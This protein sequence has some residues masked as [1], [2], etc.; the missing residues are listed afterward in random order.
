MRIL[1]LTPQLPYPL[2]QGTAI[3]NFGLIQGLARRHE[4]S[5]LSFA[6]HDPTAGSATSPSPDLG[7]LTQLCHRVETVAVPPPRSI[8][9]R[10]L[11]TL[12]HPLPDMALRLASPAFA[13][14]LNTWLQQETFDI[15]HVEGIEMTPY[16]QQLTDERWAEERNR[17]TIVFDDHNCE[18][19]LQKRYAQVDA[20][21][22]RRWPGALYSLVQW[23]KLRRYEAAICRRAHHVLAVSQTDALALQALVPGLRVT[24]IPNGIDTDSYVLTDADEGQPGEPGQPPT[25]VFI[26]KMDFRPNVDAV[27]WFASTIWP[28][29]RAKVPEARFLAVGQ[30]PHPQL[31]PLRADPSVTLTGWV[32]QVEPYIKAATLYV[33]PLRMGSGTRLK[34][35]EAMVLGKAIV[36]TRIGAEGLTDSGLIANDRELRLVEDDDPDG[37]SDAVISLLH[38]PAHRE[39]LGAA[40]HVFVKRYYDWQVII[41]QLEALYARG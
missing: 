25:L 2:H 16:F 31:D 15:V 5:L 18:Y 7:P 33:V 32:E 39:R 11:D 1:F 6:S 41:P 36:S 38:D 22:P 12:V 17:P 3:R 8:L 14:R 26:G 35:L 28:R 4:V 23:Q 29:I 20:R 10:A 40:A 27:R 30:R 13:E 21:V 24:V 37:F 34:L 19:M 9:R